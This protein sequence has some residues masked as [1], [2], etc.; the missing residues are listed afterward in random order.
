MGSIRRVLRAEGL[1]RRYGDRTV[2]D[3]VDVHA[4]GGEVVAILG[5]NGAGK[6]TLLSLLAGLQ[7][8]DAGAVGR[9]AREVG[10]VPQQPAV[11]RRLSVRENLVL[12]AR[13]ERVPEP[14]ARVDRMLAEAGLVDRA[15]DLVGSLSGGGQQRVNVAAGLVADPPVVLLDEPSSALDPRQRERMWR[16]LTGLAAAGRAVV[17]STHDV[18]EAERYADRLIVLVAGRVAFAGTPAALAAEAGGDLLRA[19]VDLVERLEPDEEHGPDG[20]EHGS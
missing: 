16:F 2:L 17:F 14:A 8:P 11:Y 4:D 10:W 9:P 6:T 20:G 3:G 5:P 15:D 1:V 19:F 18:S 7:A 13:L 12:F